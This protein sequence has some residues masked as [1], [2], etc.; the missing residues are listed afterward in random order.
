MS[1]LLD[2]HSGSSQAVFLVSGREMAAAERRPCW[3][4]RRASWLCPGRADEALQTP[5]PWVGEVC[6]HSQSKPSQVCYLKKKRVGLQ[7]LRLLILAKNAVD[8]DHDPVA[9]VRSAL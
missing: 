9:A 8:Q 5:G 7:C 2:I 3:M 6:S 1:Q 4:E